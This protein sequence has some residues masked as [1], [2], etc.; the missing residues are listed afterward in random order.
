M[1]RKLQKLAKRHQKQLLF[2]ICYEVFIRAYEYKL[3]RAFVSLFYTN[4]SPSSFIFVYGCYNSGTTVLKDAISLGT[5]Y[6]SI[7]VE[8]DLLTSA[9]P[10]FEKGEWPRALFGNAYEVE[11]YRREEGINKKQLFKDWAPW[12]R[13]KE[14]FIEKSIANSLKVKQLHALDDNYKSI[15]VVRRPEGVIRGIRKRSKPGP[16]A[17]KFLQS[18]EFP[19]DFLLNQWLY[20]YKALLEDSG[21]DSNV[22]FV[23]YEDFIEN[24]SLVLTH[25]KK[26]LGESRDG[27][28]FSERNIINNKQSL[29]ILASKTMPELISPYFKGVDVALIDNVERLYKELQEKVSYER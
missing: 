28:S 29:E 17:S 11:L 13:D 27:L 4:K 22:I 25:I 1:L 9:L 6:A 10:N 15:V 16:K 8:G 20:I 7:P 2:A 12:M 5:S 14:V 21:N 26:H 23:N 24:P 19:I 3:V 18:S